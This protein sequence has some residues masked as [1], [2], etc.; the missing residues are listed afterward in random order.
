MYDLDKIM[1]E[2]NTLPEYDTQICL[3]GVRHDS[4]PFSGIGFADKIKAPEEKF[5]CNLFDLPYTNK[6]IEDL[7]MYR[8]RVLRMHPKTCYTYHMDYTKR[9][10]IPV[11]TNP[12]CFMVLQ[13]EIMWLPADGNYYEV[14]TRKYHTFVNASTEERI[15][16]VG[17]INV[18]RYD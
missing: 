6:I 7:G 5:V 15:H 9:I 16:I 12:K 18:S 10:H 4:D 3:Q 14:D 11:K 8:T 2:L 1:N 13:N 17:C